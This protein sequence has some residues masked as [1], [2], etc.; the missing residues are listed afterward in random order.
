MSESRLQRSEHERRTSHE[1]GK[2]TIATLPPSPPARDPA[3]SPLIDLTESRLLGSSSTVTTYRSPAVQSPAA[4]V[5]S[6]P[7]R[8]WRQLTATA[9]DDDLR[10][11]VSSPRRNTKRWTMANIVKVSL[12]E[13]LPIDGYSSEDETES[14][15]EP[16]RVN[17]MSPGEVQAVDRAQIEQTMY[18]LKI[19]RLMLIV[20]TRH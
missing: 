1:T 7:Q 20:R 18:L 9:P 13:A 8:A 3:A 16:S 10:K 19:I 5:A 4:A 11:I 15:P 17:Q 14:K 6:S 2:A 12:P